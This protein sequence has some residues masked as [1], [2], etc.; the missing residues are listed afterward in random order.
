MRLVLQG[1]KE[2]GLKLRR[3]TCFFGLKEIEY[4]SY[5]VSASRFFVSTKKV[6]T[7][8]PASMHTGQ[9][10]RG[11]YMLAGVYDAEGG[12]QFRAIQ[13]LQRHVYSSF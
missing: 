10:V 8:N 9:Y 4:L 5:I 3:K 7:K 12:S 11:R 6:E 13:E 2:E 1:F